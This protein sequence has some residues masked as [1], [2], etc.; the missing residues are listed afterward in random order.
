M[1]KKKIEPIEEKEPIVEAVESNEADLDLLDT[2][3]GSLSE[4]MPDV[5][6]HAIDAE[7][8]KAEAIKSEYS[9]L[10]DSKGNSFDPEL[11][12]TDKDGAPDL[13]PKGKL[14]VKP[15]PRSFYADSRKGGAKSVVD[16]GSEKR[17]ALELKQQSRASGAM[18][19]NLLIVVSC[20]AGGEEWQPRV[21]VENGLDE[22][23]ILENAFSDY[24][25]A[26]G[27]I[28]IPPSMGLIIAVGSY[29]LPR[30]TMPKTKERVKGFRAK[31]KMWFAN[32]K[33]KKHG[34]EAKALESATKKETVKKVQP[35]VP[36]AE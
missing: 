26:T 1:T 8:G 20:V 32:R 28:D 35:I 7:A 25:E 29:A 27:R 17:N 5:Q 12:R 21:S 16:D 34:L 13:T 14:R 11:H 23:L 15:K 6:Q 19:A 18:A 3:A 31:I 2:I 22:K 4:E 9:D 30:F 10:K 33:L 24:F 36:K